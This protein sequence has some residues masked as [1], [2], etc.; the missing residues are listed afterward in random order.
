MSENYS[1]DEEN[2]RKHLGVIDSASSQNKEFMGQSNDSSR[3]TLDMLDYI[4]VDANMLPCG[5]FYPIGTTVMVRPCTVKEIQVYSTIDENY[6]PDI[7]DKMNYMLMSC[8]RVKFIDG[9]IGSYLDIKD[10]DR[11]YLIF[12]IRELTFQNGASLAIDVKL[13]DGRDEKIELVRNNFR[14]FDIEAKFVKYYREDI[15]AFSFKVKGG[16]TFVMSPPTIGIQKA[17]SEYVETSRSNKV[18]VNMAFI[19]IIPYLIN[20]TTITQEGI[21]LELERFESMD[22]K[23]FQFL[24]SV[25]SNMKFGIKSLEKEFNGEIVTTDMRFPSGARGIFVIQDAFDLFIEE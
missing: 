3:S 22:D 6:F 10:Q 4:S 1:K 15:G 19:R 11:F 12:L 20:R 2:L 16:N 13:S 24:D 9:R 5:A 25:V 21:K 7:V 23:S 8:V 17:F 14:F 18:E